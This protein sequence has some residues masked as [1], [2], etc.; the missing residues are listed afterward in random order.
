MHILE[1][2]PMA[3]HML[4][5]V[6]HTCELHLQL[7]LLKYHGVMGNNF[8]KYYLHVASY[9]EFTVLLLWQQLPYL[10]PHVNIASYRM[11]GNF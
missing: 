9:L 6:L 11:A 2:S 7:I 5:Y 10:Y 1:C 8:I 4:L 3:A